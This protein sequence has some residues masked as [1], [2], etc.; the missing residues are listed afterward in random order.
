MMGI[1]EV[2]T[3]ARSPWQNAYVE[4]II[5]SVRRESLDHVIVLNEKPSGDAEALA[6]RAAFNCP[7]GAI[8]IIEEA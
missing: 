5:G 3:A 6:R 8:T 2:V 4:R 7:T 1:K